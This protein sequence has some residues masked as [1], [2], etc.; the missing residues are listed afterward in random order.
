MARIFV[1]KV[2]NISPFKDTSESVELSSQIL[3]A[4]WPVGKNFV[5]L[6]GKFNLQTAQGRGKTELAPANGVL[7]NEAMDSSEF[8]RGKTFRAIFQRSHI[9]SRT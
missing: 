3:P 9:L 5:Q 6:S 2:G 4:N 8:L 7:A 1:E